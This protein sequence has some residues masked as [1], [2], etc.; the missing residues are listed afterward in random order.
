MTITNKR[1]DVFC[2]TR[3]RRFDLCDN[4][5]MNWPLKTRTVYLAIST[6][7]EDWMRWTEANLLAIEELVRYDLN[8]DHCRVVLQ[9]LTTAKPAPPCSEPFRWQLRIRNTFMV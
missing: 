4:L 8:A 9:R 7:G 1:G 5:I 6:T 2:Q 3:K